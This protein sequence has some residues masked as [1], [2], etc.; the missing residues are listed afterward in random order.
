MDRLI[1]TAMTGAKSL[2]DRQAV[3][4][5]NLSNIS[6]LGYRAETTAF[7]GMLVRGQGMLTREMVTESTTGV[8]FTPGP[9]S[10]TGR[11]LDMAVQGK[12]WIAVQAPDGSEAYTRAGSFRISTEG[13]LETHNG[14]QVLSD[15]GPIAIPADTT[16][17]IGADGTIS[18][19]PSQPPLTS[20]SV[21]GRIKLVNPDEK[22]LKKGPDGLFRVADGTAPVDET[23]ALVGGAVEGSNVN[24]AE[25]IVSM[26]AVSRQFELQMKMLQNAETNAQQA[27]QIL[28]INV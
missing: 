20:V 7:Q 26:I 5:N 19:I 1:Y 28:T 21:V 15:A 9:L 23:V 11:D 18:A 14:Y 13:N 6:T 24:P 10:Q 8:D 12:G 4:S 22:D 16:I 3:V 2:L 17:T 27:D 25:A